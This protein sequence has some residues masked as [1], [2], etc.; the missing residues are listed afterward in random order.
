MGKV[1]RLNRLVLNTDQER[2]NIKRDKRVTRILW[3]S[4]GVVFSIIINQFLKYL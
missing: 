3:F 2:F 4:L 1:Y